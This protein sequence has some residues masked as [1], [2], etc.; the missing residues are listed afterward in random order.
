MCTEVIGIGTRRTLDALI[1]IHFLSDFNDVAC[2][3]A[4]GCKYSHVVYE[5]LADSDAKL[6]ENAESEHL[7]VP[8]VIGLLIRAHTFVLYFVRRG[9]LA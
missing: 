2:T 3:Y 6:P 4:S 5:Q 1:S 9:P 7:V 8:T